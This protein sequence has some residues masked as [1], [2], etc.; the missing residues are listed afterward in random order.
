MG[1]FQFGLCPN[2]KHTTQ[3]CLDEHLLKMVRPQDNVIE[4]I[5]RY[6]PKDGNKVYEMRYRLPKMVCPHCVLQ[7]RYISG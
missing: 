5:T 1:Y 2:Y 4:G 3:E 6:Y 7:W